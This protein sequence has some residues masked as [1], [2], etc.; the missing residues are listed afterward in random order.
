MAQDRSSVHSRTES[1]R[2]HAN[3]TFTL[4]SQITGTPFT[5][6]APNRYFGQ[7]A[8]FVAHFTQINRMWGTHNPTSIQFVKSL[9]MWFIKLMHAPQRSER[10]HMHMCFQINPLLF[11]REWFSCF[12]SGWR[13]VS[14][15]I[16]NCTDCPLFGKF[17]ADACCGVGIALFVSSSLL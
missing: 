8:P 7:V 11:G 5:N 10:A 6:K 12:L 3:S 13:L 9:E 14:V 1:L 4:F 17:A 15:L 2:T 16:S